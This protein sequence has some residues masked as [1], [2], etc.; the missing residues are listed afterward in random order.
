MLASRSRFWFRAVKNLF[1]DNTAVVCLGD[2]LHQDVLRFLPEKTRLVSIPNTAPEAL[3][4]ASMHRDNRVVYFS[5]L[6]PEKGI[7][8]FLELARRFE[9]ES[10]TRFVAAGRPVSQVQLSDLTS[11]APPNAEVIG[12]V[13][14]AEKVDLFAS[15]SMLVF[16][17]TYRFEAQPLT[18]LE[19]LSGGVPVV[20]YDVGGIADLIRHGENGLLVPAGDVSRLQDAV[21]GLLH[22]SKRLAAMSESARRLYQERFSR[23]AYRNA[24]EKELRMSCA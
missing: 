24:W 1:H 7:E 12:G 11:K 3:D 10:D 22:D 18:I 2:S 13:Y 14:G 8:D 17:S 19:A 6:I 16:P 5:N 15:A 4:P 21:Q 23:D 20:A 9:K